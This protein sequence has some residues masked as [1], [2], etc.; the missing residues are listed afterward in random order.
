MKAE[1]AALVVV[2]AA[3]TLPTGTMA[4]GEIVL[5][6]ELPLGEWR[7]YLLDLPE[8]DWSLTSR[9]NG[10]GEFGTMTVA[11]DAQGIAFLTATCL[12]N[13]TKYT[14]RA[15][16]VLLDNEIEFT[17]GARSDPAR[18]T[19]VVPGAMDGGLYTVVVMAAGH[20]GKAAYEF[21]FPGQGSIVSMTAGV[22]AFLWGPEDLDPMVAV[23]AETSGLAER[24]HAQVGARREFGVAGSLVAYVDMNWPGGFGASQLTFP[25]GDVMH[26]PCRPGDLGSAASGPGTYA[27][28]RT[29]VQATGHD[30]PVVLGAS[31]DVPQSADTTP[32]IPSDT[33]ADWGRAD[34]P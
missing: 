30:S 27:F 26:C 8:G 29:W 23:A 11:Y 15:R 25:N 16:V 21:R 4:T 3:V 19:C 5:A 17:S 28:E 22:G 7:A 20:A 32:V 33:L 34:T 18:G 31:I 24:P 2:L 6:D 1:L 9:L 12:Q 14:P 10:S 13:S